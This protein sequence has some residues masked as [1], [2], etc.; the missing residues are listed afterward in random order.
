[1]RF[2]FLLFAAALCN[3]AIAAAPR[4]VY[5]AGSLT[6]LNITPT[7]DKGYL[8]VYAGHEINVFGP[9]GTQLF[10]IS[11]Q[12][13][14]AKVSSIENA[15]ADTDGTIAGAV[16]YYPDGSRSREG[17]GVAVFDRSGKQVRFFDTGRYHA[18]QIAFGPDHSIWTLGCP[19]AQHWDDDFFILRNYSQD[20]EELG[21]FLPRSSFDAAP[22]PIGPEIGT[23]QLRV[24]RD[25][26]GAIIYESPVYRQNQKNR[27]VVWVETDLRGQELGRWEVGANPA[28]QA[29][30]ESGNL[31][32][33]EGKSV[34]VFDRAAKAWRKVALSAD[35]ILLGADGDNLV[36][37]QGQNTLQWVAAEQ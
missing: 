32:I 25:R 28:P 22:D 35:G 2:G 23:W 24:I 31:Y 1:M 34:S 30:T 26:V 11:A 4:E 17:G 13:A 16:T 7:F 36:F 10:G 21:H 14:L 15:A 8:F 5:Y 37:L 12:V 9:D 33:R 19:S 3:L 29:F 20:G 18:T 27:A 6:P